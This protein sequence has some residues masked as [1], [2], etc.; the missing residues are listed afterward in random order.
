[1]ALFI[2]RATQSALQQIRKNKTKTPKKN[3]YKSRLKDSTLPH[4][5]PQRHSWCAAMRKDSRN[6]KLK[7]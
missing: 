4:P 1:M 5:T 3:N 7:Q 2:E 6:K